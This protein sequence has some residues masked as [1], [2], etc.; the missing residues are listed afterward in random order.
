MMQ[1]KRFILVVVLTLAV[2]AL[3]LRT[4]LHASNE[5]KEAKAAVDR[6]VRG[7]ADAVRS[8]KVESFARGSAEEQNT[9]VNEGVRDRLAEEL[10]KIA[11]VYDQPIDARLVQQLTR[12]VSQF[13]YQRFM[14]EDLDG[15]INW[16]L[17]SGYRFRD[18]ELMYVTWM[19]AK[20]Y[21]SLMSEPIPEDL[22]M[23]QVFE[24]VARAEDATS[25]A[26][27]AGLAGMSLSPDAL[28]VQ[29]RHHSA[30]Q[31]AP[32]SAFH[33]QEQEQL[34][35]GPGM[36]SHRCWFTRSLPDAPSPLRYIEGQVGMVFVDAAGNRKQLWVSAFLDDPA[37]EWSI[38]YLWTREYGGKGVLIEY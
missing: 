5:V 20:D 23:R 2:V 13:V 38:E 27:G 24:R 16:R 31:D 9:L 26:A 35:T 25:T 19:V 6:I 17:N 28:F 8:F 15:Y 30:E 18:K 34:W 21:E 4:T 36:G 10:S 12:A 22:P 11:P 37:G 33:S 29:I 32:P 14:R 7:N 1:P 3:A